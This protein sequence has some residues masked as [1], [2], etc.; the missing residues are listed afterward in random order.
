MPLAPTA[1]QV[2]GACRPQHRPGRGVTARYAP[3]EPGRAH[4]GPVPYTDAGPRLDQRRDAAPS[5]RSLPMMPIAP[6]WH[7]ALSCWACGRPKLPAYGGPRW[8][9][10]NRDPYP[11]SGARPTAM[12]K[13]FPSETTKSASG[14]SYGDPYARISDPT[15][16]ASPRPTGGP[17]RPK[18]VMPTT[19]PGMGRYRFGL[20]VGYRGPVGSSC[21]PEAI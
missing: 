7:L 1:L 17:I 19:W 20:Y 21:P 12:G 6:Y 11:W 4:R 10:D 13:T 8:T 9:S 3:S 16:E 14:R 5:W 18:G 2:Q 15:S